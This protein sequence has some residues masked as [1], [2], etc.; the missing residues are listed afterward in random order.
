M[1]WYLGFYGMTVPKDAFT[2]AVWQSVRALEIDD[3]LAESHALLGMLRKELDYD[4]SEIDRARALLDEL[5]ALSRSSYVS[6]FSI[7]II[8]L[9]LED[10]DGAFEWMDRAVDMRDPMVI[11]ILSYPFLQPLKTDPRFRALAAKMTSPE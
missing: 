9:G 11:P 3:R 8:S 10:I 7:A 6:P 1:Y 5:L 4:W 2:F